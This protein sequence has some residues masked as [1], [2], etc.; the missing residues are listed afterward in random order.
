MGLV[1]RGGRNAGRGQLRSGGSQ[2]PGRSPRP[3]PA[4]LYFS[5]FLNFVSTVAHSSPPDPLNSLP[6]PLSLLP[7]IG[8][9]SPA[10]VP[11]GRCRLLS[12]TRTAR[13]GNKS[14]FH[15]SL[16]SSNAPNLSPPRSPLRARGAGWA[17]AA[18]RA[19][20]GVPAGRGAAG[21]V[22]PGVRS[23]ECG[24]DRENGG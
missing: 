12:G 5:S 13:A 17:V 6:L 11:T 3:R 8:P 2:Y 10:R 18:V 24:L 14:R 4:S 23:G 19:A 9:S 22:W 15:D 16:P 7:V 21:S 20:A 1:D